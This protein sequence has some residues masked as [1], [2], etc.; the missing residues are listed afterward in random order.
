MVI[1]QQHKSRMA[2]VLLTLSLLVSGCEAVSN[3]EMGAGIGSV[4]G[5]VIGNQIGSG[6]GRYAATALGVLIGSWIGM[7]IGYE[8]D[9]QSH[10]GYYDSY[11][12]RNYNGSDAYY[13][14]TNNRNQQQYQTNRMVDNQVIILADGSVYDPVSKRIVGYVND[15]Y[16][17]P[18]NSYV[19]PATFY[20][21]DD[22]NQTG[23]ENR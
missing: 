18:M 9:K 8:M 16:Y 4:A 12:T 3:R 20:N 2:A 22:T 19:E 10:N 6:S 13:T 14:R 1:F 17:P 21:I 7:G 15:G 5:G 23:W 11:D